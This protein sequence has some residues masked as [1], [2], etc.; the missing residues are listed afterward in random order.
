MVRRIP[1]PHDVRDSL[2]AALAEAEGALRDA[3]AAGVVPDERRAQTAGLLDT[4]AALRRR[5]EAAFA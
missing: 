1:T 3:A 5:I 2:E 4:L